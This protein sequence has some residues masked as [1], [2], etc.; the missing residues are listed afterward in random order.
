MTST[1]VIIGFAAICL[2]ILL[3]A[4]LVLWKIF[5]G[6]I[7]ICTMLQESPPTGVVPTKAGDPPAPL[8]IT[9]T[10]FS[11]FQFLVFTFVVA[12]LFLLLSIESGTFV[13][14][15]NSVL[16]LLG[17]SATSF[18]VSKITD[19]SKTKPVTPVLP[20]PPVPL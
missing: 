6:C 17:I 19:A 14:I 20:V 13:E 2:I 15:P 5:T 1:I 3:F 10:S 8:P 18:G 16:G 9:K 7:D 11:R 12:G 4:F